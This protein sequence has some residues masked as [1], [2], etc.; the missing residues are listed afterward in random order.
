MNW[1]PDGKSLAIDT[2]PYGALDAHRRHRTSSS[3]RLE[4][5]PDVDARQTEWSPTGEWIAASN[6]KAVADS[7]AT[8][9]IRPSDGTVR[10]LPGLPGAARAWSK[11]GKLLY[12]IT[13]K[14]QRFRIA[15]A[16]YCA[17]GTVPHGRDLQ[18]ASSESRTTS[19]ER[20]GCRS[21]RQDVRSPTTM[22]TDQLNVW[23]LKGLQRR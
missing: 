3:R 16:R 4:L 18:H 1:A 8:L 22:V 7:A 6:A 21:I 12:S 11:D 5:P 13:A 9:L 20:S 23:L 17:T 15:D 14:R 2:R 19:T 10:R